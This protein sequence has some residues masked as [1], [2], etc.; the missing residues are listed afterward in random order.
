MATTFPN[1]TV[2]KETVRAMIAFENVHAWYMKDFGKIETF[3]KNDPQTKTHIMLMHMVLK[4]EM[5]SGKSDAWEKVVE[6][7]YINVVKN[8]HADMERLMLLETI[9]KQYQPM[10]FICG[11]EY[12][13]KPIYK[14]IDE[15]L[16]NMLMDLLVKE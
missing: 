13:Y 8:M 5:L 4:A 10:V 9:L 1:I 14:L 12:R 6:A 16:E 15:V 11:N 3:L 7:I 2:R